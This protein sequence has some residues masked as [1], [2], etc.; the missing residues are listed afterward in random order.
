MKYK[1]IYKKKYKYVLT[2][3]AVF[4]IPLIKR[5]TPLFNISH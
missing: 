1:K 4:Y 2:E 5:E 3:G